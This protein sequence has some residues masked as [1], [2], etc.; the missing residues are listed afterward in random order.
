[1]YAAGVYLLTLVQG[2][3]R[4]GV[5][6]VLRADGGE[7]HERDGLA[8]ASQLAA[9]A[10]VVLIALAH[11]DVLKLRLVYDGAEGG[12]AAVIRPVGV[13]HSQ[14]GDARV[15]PGAREVGAAELRVVRVHG[16]THLCNQRL[17]PRAVELCKALHALYVGRLGVVGGEGLPRRESGLAALHGV[18]DAVLHGRERGLVHLAVQ[19]VDLG[20]EHARPL[21]AGY[22]LD[23]LGAAV[24]AL[25]ELSGQV[26]DGEDRVGLRQLVEHVVHLRLA[27]HDGQALFKQRG[28]H[29]LDIIAVQKPQPGQ[30]GDTGQSVELLQRALSLL[31]VGRALF[32][33]YSVDHFQPSN[34]ESARAPMSRRQCISSKLI[35][36]ASA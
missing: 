33:I 2:A 10:Q 11:L 28:V 31:V 16:Q 12:V 6:E 34:A 5:L 29:A 17:K 3:Q 23:A 14:L 7:V 35:F 25:V 1:M 21:G 8:L 19:Q 36:P 26:F 30:A 13:Q 15:A 18:Y 24:G 4:T 32:H 27:E 9:D 22:Q 20:A